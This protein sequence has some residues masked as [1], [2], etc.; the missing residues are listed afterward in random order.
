MAVNW[1]D[2]AINTGVDVVLI[3]GDPMDT[4]IHVTADFALAV[5]T[6]LLKACPDDVKAT[7]HRLMVRRFDKELREALDL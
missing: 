6:I 3:E 4:G 2:H 7:V 5:S 1:L